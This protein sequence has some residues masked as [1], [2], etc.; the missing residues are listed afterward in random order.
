MKL[1]V[2]NWDP[3]KFGQEMFKIAVKQIENDKEEK[4]KLA[5]G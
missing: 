2:R 5:T 1:R 4:T 3:L